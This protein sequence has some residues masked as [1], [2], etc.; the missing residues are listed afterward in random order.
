MPPALLGEKETPM[1]SEDPMALAP[2]P[3]MAGQDGSSEGPIRCIQ[4]V[5]HDDLGGKAR[6]NCVYNTK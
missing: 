5:S 2:A 4:L 3:G 6:G 1:R